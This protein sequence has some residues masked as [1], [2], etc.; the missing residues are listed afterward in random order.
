MMKLVKYNGKQTITPHELP[1]R[2]KQGATGQD[3]S[4]DQP[5]GRLRGGQGH[6]YLYNCKTTH[7]SMFTLP[8]RAAQNTGL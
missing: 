7:Q 5:I 8:G 2:L 6:Q 3:V 1:D 4:P